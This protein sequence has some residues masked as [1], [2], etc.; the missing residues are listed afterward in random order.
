MYVMLICLTR[1]HG[2]WITCPTFYSLHIYILSLL[3]PFRMKIQ[4]TS[5][6]DKREMKPLQ[7]A[8]N[9]ILFSDWIPLLGGHETLL[10]QRL[11]NNLFPSHTLLSQQHFIYNP[12]E[13]W[14]QKG[15]KGRDYS[16][17]TLSGAVIFSYSL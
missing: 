16:G 4:W 10:S 7:L 11:I 3:P 14:M 9:G 8:I 2:S 12:T 17:I 5:C 6:Q 13:T 15:R 1:K